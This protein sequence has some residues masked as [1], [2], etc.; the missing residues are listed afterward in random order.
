MATALLFQDRPQQRPQLRR[1]HRLV[2]Q[3]NVGGVQLRFQR[4]AA[5]GRDHHRWHP[6]TKTRP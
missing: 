2:E 6:K 4:F 3:G 5:V 1:L